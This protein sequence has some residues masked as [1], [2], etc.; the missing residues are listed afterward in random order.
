[1]DHFEL[2]VEFGIDPG[3]AFEHVEIV[4]K[5]MGKQTL[6]VKEMALDLSRSNSEDFP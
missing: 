3:P 2:A 1:M 4:K 5:N 6:V